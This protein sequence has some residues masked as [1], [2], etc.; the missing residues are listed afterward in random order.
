MKIVLLGKYALNEKASD[1]ALRYAI[2]LARGLEAQE[3]L[4]LHIVTLGSKAGDWSVG[5]KRVHVVPLRRRPFERMLF[6]FFPLVRKL[7]EIEPDL[8]HCIGTT[9]PYALPLWY[10]VRRFGYKG[11]VSVLGIAQVEAAF[12]F[13][14]PRYILHRFFFPFVERQILQRFPVI[15]LTDNI[16]RRLAPWTRHPVWVIPP[17][18]DP[19]FLPLASMRREDVVKPGRILCI[20]VVERRKGLLDLLEALWLLRDRYPSVHLV[21][22]GK[23]VSQTYK[24]E[25]EA[26]IHQHGLEERVQFLGRVTEARL[27]E[28][29]LR[30]EVFVLPSY[31]ESFGLVLVEAMAAGVPVI[32]TRIGG[33]QEVVEE[34]RSGLLV[35]PGDPVALAGKIAMV[36]EDRVLRDR[37]VQAG[38]ER[39]RAFSW[40]AVTARVFRLYRQLLEA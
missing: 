1:G 13:R 30:A 37:L 2:G 20:S 19:H 10:S 35:P 39:A 24:R 38:K 22:A 36:F 15:V 14:S 40:E 5:R 4:E 6:S 7:R 29:L 34:G 18:I 16:R 28:L 23:V 31:E 12:W 9:Q 26:Y 8:V 25:L 3:G 27:L 21:H 17:G 33:I 32:S 11:L